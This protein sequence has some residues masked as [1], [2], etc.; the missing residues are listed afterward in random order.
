MAFLWVFPGKVFCGQVQV[1]EM[2]SKRKKRVGGAIFSYLD[3]G[4]ANDGCI[5][6]QELVIL[7]SV[8]GGLSSGVGSGHRSGLFD[9]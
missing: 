7:G 9:L 2:V 6:G 5:L 1:V 8:S 4:W 3:I